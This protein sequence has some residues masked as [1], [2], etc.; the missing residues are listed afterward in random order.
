MSYQLSPYH[1]EHESILISF[2]DKCLPESNRCLDIDGR[3]SYYKEISTHFKGFWCLYDGERIIGTVAISELSGD[4]CELKSLYLLEEYHSRGY[5]KRMLEHAIEN[6]RDLGYKKMY[7]DSLSS[8]KKAIALYRRAGFA[9]TE[10]YNQSKYS[11]V[12]MVLEL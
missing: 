8:S 6:A 9:H 10:K 4:S 12:F 3:H 5:G 11:D 2:L 7:L 1:K